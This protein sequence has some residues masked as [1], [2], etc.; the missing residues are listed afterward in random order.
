MQITT[1]DNNSRSFEYRRSWLDFRKR[2]VEVGVDGITIDTGLPFLKKEK[3]LSKDKIEGFRYGIH[4]VRGI[5]FYV[6]LDF[7]F[8]FLL[9]DQSVVSLTYRSYYGHAK[10]QHH[11]LFSQVLD[12]IWNLIFVQ[13]MKEILQALNEGKEV[14]VSKV[15]LSEKGVTIR[16]GGIIVDEENF[17]PWQE[18]ATADYAS[19]FVIYSTKDKTHINCSYRYLDDWNTALLNGVI[20]TILEHVK[21]K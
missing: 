15:K 4:W 8:Y 5:Y 17:I 3:Y 6:A 10:E 14:I 9:K 12:T 13:R 16:R 2:K 21:L 18:V 7:K 1:P 19:Y 20:R 11:E